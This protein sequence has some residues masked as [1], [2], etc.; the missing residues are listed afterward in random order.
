MGGGGGSG[1]SV[2]PEAGWLDEV[3]A[4]PEAGWVDG[5]L[6]GL[7]ATPGDVLLSRISRTS[8]GRKSS[9]IATPYLTTSKT[10][11]AAVRLTS[12]PSYVLP[13]VVIN[14]SAAATETSGI[15]HANTATQRVIKSTFLGGTPKSAW[16]CP[17]SARLHK[18]PQADLGVPQAPS[19]PIR[20]GLGAPPIG[21]RVN[22]RLGLDSWRSSPVSRRIS[23]WR[24]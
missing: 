16:G 21:A 6:A 2:R 11:F 22:R 7:D 17:D 12:R 1:I 15:M 3:L 8:W 19:G 23:S 10:I 24:A 5:V 4:G 20:A 18:H 14:V 9:G 13:S